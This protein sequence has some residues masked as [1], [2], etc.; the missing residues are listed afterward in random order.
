MHPGRITPLSLEGLPR[1]P[2][3]ATRATRVLAR[4]GLPATLVAQLERVG[5]VRLRMARLA[6]V[7]P[8]DAGGSSF[9]LELRGQPARLTVE[10]LLAL[11]V[12]AAVLGLPQPL[13]VRPL[14]RSERGVLAAAIATFL[15]AAGADRSA[16]VA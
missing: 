15:E 14:G 5:T 16:R 6:F 8:P 2:R 13:A 3:A 9:A 11:R 4:A 1:L 7:V 10:P 12:V